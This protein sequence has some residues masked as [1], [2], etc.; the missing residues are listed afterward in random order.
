[1]YRKYEHRKFNKRSEELIEAINEIIAI[2]EANGLSMSVRQIHYQLVN[3]PDYENSANNVNNL[4][5]LISNA[6]MAGLVSW[7]AIED[8]TRPFYDQAYTEHPRDVFKGLDEGFKLNKWREQDFMPE[9]WVEKESQID[10]IGQIC[11][12]LEVPFYACKGYNSQSMAWRAGR[13]MQ[14]YAK[15]GQRPIIFHLGDLDPSG[16]DMTRDNRERLSLFA[17]FPVNVQRIALN[18]DQ[19]REFEPWP[20]PLKRDAGG[21]LTDSRAQAFRDEFGDE[22]YELDSLTSTQIQHIIEEAV[23]RVRDRVKWD[24]AVEQEVEHKR[25][26]TDL[27][28]TLGFESDSDDDE[29]D[30]DDGE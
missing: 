5:E 4:G 21:K 19:V 7:T 8:R 16:W 2:E 15:R 9:V 12:K 28:E 11:N 25:Y 20:N 23:L 14:R 24:A 13:R 1:M 26:I 29:E 6:R 3:R 17:G 10:V 22:S 30:D 27:I 18:M